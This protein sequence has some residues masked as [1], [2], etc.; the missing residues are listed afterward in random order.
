[1][2]KNCFFCQNYEIMLGKTSYFRRLTQPMFFITQATTS[3]QLP[4]RARDE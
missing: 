2:I 4:E 1:M 3:R